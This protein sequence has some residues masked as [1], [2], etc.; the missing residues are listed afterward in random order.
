MVQQATNL[1]AII[2]VLI[3]KVIHVN[4]WCTIYFQ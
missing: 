1:D 2:I 4:S 3:W